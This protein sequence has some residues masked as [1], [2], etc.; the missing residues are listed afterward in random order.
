[1]G[2][3]DKVFIKIVKDIRYQL[4]K[5]IMDITPRIE[6]PLTMKCNDG[7]SSLALSF[8]KTRNHIYSRLDIEREMFCIAYEETKDKEKTNNIRGEWRIQQK[9]MAELQEEIFKMNRQLSLYS[10]YSSS[11]GSVFT[12]ILAKTLTQDGVIANLM[13]EQVN[14][15][16]SILICNIV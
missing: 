2:V 11:Q 5:V 10:D 8:F 9:R 3:D 15:T 16:V 12:N 13:Q 7:E 1:M 6:K 14:M 4:L